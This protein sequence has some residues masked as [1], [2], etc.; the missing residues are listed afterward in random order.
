MSGTYKI[1]QRVMPQDKF[2]GG[3]VRLM[4]ASE[5]YAMVRRGTEPPFIVTLEEWCQW[6]LHRS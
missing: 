2:G 1:H 3:V 5:G 4:L 6:P